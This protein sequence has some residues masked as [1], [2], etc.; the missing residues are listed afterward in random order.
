MS[1]KQPRAA[2]RRRLPKGPSQGQPQGPSQGQPQGPSQGQP[3]GPSQ[4]PS[5]DASASE[6][7]RAPSAASLHSVGQTTD[8]SDTESIMSVS[9]CGSIRRESRKRFLRQKSGGSPDT[10]RT[11]AKRAIVEAD[12]EE[13]V[14][15]KE[16]LA[17]TTRAKA[18][19]GAATVR[20]ADHSVEEMERMA[21]EDQG[22]IIEVASKSSNLKGTFQ[23]ALKCR[24]ASLIGIVKELSQRTT[25]NETRLLQAK[26]DRL[27][28]EMS[29]LQ[30]RIAE[31]MARSKGTSEGPA[32]AAAPSNLEDIIRKVVMEERAFT[33]ACFAGIED[34]LLPEKR[35]RPPLGRTS[36][37]PPPQEAAPAQK[38]QPKATKAGK[39]KGKGKKSPSAPT[40]QAGASAAPAPAQAPVREDALLPSTTPSNEPWKKV[41]GKKQRKGKKPVPESPAANKAP[42]G[43]RRKLVPPKTAAVVVTLTAEAVTR[44]E[45][46]ES[47]LRRAR[48]NIDPVQP[49]EGRVTCRRTQTGARIFEFSGAQGSAKADTFASQL[50]EVIADTAKIARPLK[51]VT[52]EVTDLDDSVNQEEVVAAVAA[53][54][55]CDIAAIKGRA[56]RP[57]RGGMGSL[58]LECPV[59]AAKAVLAKGRLPVGFSSAGVRALEDEP[60]RCYKCFGIGHTRALC[61]SAA[62]RT[63]LCFRCGKGGHRSTACEATKPHCAVC[64]DSG[65]PADHIMTG[66]KCRP[67]LK[68][69]KAQVTT[70]PAA[71]AV[72]AIPVPVPTTEGSAMNTD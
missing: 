16:K 71:A 41:V 56:I 44:G 12:L 47:V 35:L 72:T 66:R 48:A 51:C 42:A 37:A 25:S 46:Y 15:S 53:L 11:P 18:G 20:Y 61:P 29:A 31:L 7:S 24:A 45:T 52:L 17:R 36:T 1:S 33:K 39:G 38:E 32:V 9:D 59:M 63:D 8:Y 5:R 62:E 64:A 21:L 27:Q 69:G 57:G 54:G 43:K 26:V 65:R 2:S 6:A 14:A 49:S 10:A 23:K 13:M 67:P 34:R 68:K 60:M 55:G 70:R 19:Y 30:A 3:K 4:G 40:S 50:K 58:R 22:E 28:K